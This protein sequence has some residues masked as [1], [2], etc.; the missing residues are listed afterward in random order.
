M[1]GK[2]RYGNKEGGGNGREEKTDRVCFWYCVFSFS[3]PSHASESHGDDKVSYVRMYRH[4]GTKG[5]EQ[6]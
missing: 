5:L 1:E 6:R 2:V 3:L 4:I